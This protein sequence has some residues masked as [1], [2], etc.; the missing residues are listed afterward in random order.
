MEPLNSATLIS[1]VRERA[2]LTQAQMAKRAGTSQAAVAR[3]ETGV[4]NPST[5][6]LQRLTRAAG[7][8]VHV[9]LVQV[10]QSNL[11]SLR[12]K[13]LRQ[14]RGAINVLLSKA[15]A[16]NPRIF[17][18]VARG[19]DDQSSDIDLLVDFDITRGLIPIIRLNENL[20]QLL[21]EKV[22]VSPLKMLKPSVL[23][24]ALL[25]AVPL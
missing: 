14:N 6:T 25:D 3:Y 11:S 7:F 12:A 15:G 10:K 17:G 19:E 22:E 13:K 20:S 9:Q 23:E 4:S 16:S 2:G 21:E 18:S 5:A 24:T 8:E 1:E